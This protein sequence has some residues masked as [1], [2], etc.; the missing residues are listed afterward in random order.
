MP[1][2]R[3][4]NA[5][6]VL[7]LQSIFASSIRTSKAIDRQA[8]AKRFAATQASTSSS[9]FVLLQNRS[10]S[11]AS[12]TTYTSTG[13]ACFD[14]GAAYDAKAGVVNVG[15]YDPASGDLRLNIAGNGVVGAT[16]AP[17]G[18]GATSSSPQ[19]V[20]FNDTDLVPPETLRAGTSYAVVAYQTVPTQLVDETVTASPCPIDGNHVSGPNSAYVPAGCNAD[21][22]DYPA[23]AY[24]IVNMPLASIAPDAL[25]TRFYGDFATSGTSSTPG[26]PRIAINYTT[27][28]S[29]SKFAY[30]D[31]STCKGALTSSTA[32]APILLSASACSII[33]NGK[34]Y[35]TY[36]A[37]LND[38]LDANASVRAT[39]STSP[40]Q[41]I[42][43]RSNANITLD[44]IRLGL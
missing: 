39:Q 16:A 17:G 40:I 25:S 26:S 31:G 2:A 30:V 14:V 9:T 41:L 43:D 18:I 3:I 20:C 32:T 22:F 5:S 11:P 19:Q 13:R 15:A 38:P 6:H 23:L 10:F 33:A 24:R 34:T 7:D 28:G 27:T 35:A 29:D 21:T 12:T 42:V 36:A 44:L 37:F 8:L 4:P 1:D